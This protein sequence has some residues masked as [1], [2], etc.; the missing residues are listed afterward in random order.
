MVEVS[1][2]GGCLC[3]QVRF[4]VQGPLREVL[5]C[6]CSQCRKMSGH[7]WAASSALRECVDI[8]EDTGLRWFQSS[9]E[10]KRGFCSFCGS[11]LFWSHAEKATLSFAAGALDGPTGLNT[12]A[13]IFFDD[14]SDYYLVH[15]DENTIGGSSY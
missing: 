5:L 10:A 2:S 7:F 4:T 3:G 14:A 13:H 12:G 15:P 6:H 1:V 11:S 8:Y 9:K